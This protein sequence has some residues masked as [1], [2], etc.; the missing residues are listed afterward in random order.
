MTN[1]LVFLA[2]P[3]MVFLIAAALASLRVAGIISQ[4]E[5]RQ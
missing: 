3:I 2:G 1:L 5:G 4:V